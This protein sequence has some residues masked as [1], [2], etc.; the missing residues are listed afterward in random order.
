MTSTVSVSCADRFL[1][2]VERS[3][4]SPAVVDGDTTITYGALAAAA[5]DLAGRLA[6]A[7]V[8]PGTL[9]GVSVPRGWHMIA[10]ML[11]VWL[12]G[13]GYVPIDPNY[14]AARRDYISADATVSHL[15]TEGLRIEATGHD[16]RRDDVPQDTAYVIYTSGT[17]GNPKGVVVRHRNLLALLD[18][19]ADAMP[20]ACDDVSS[21]FHSANFDLS[22]W[23][24]W[25]PLLSGASC[26]VVPVEATH[27]ANALADLFADHG[28]T[29]VTLVPS[30]FANFVAELVERPVA[31]PRLRELVFCGEPIGRDT[32]GT[33]YDLDVAPHAQLV[34]MYGP[35]ETTVYVSWKNLDRALVADRSEPGTPIGMPLPHLRVRLLDDDRQPATAG[36][37]Y[38]AGG[39]VSAGYLGRPELTADRFVVLDDGDVWY[40]SGDHAVLGA[41][42]ELRFLGRKDDQVKIRGFRI[43]LGEVDAALRGLPEIA[44]AGTVVQTT[45]AGEPILVAG[46]VP[47]DRIDS[48]A[49]E[50]TVRA[51]LRE[52]LPQHMIPTRLVR[53]PTLPLSLSGKLN[54]RALAQRLETMR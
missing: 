26:V 21:V 36:E 48:P 45:S 51:R 14:P 46:Y 18:A 4:G 13:C 33:W 19:A 37:V 54:R 24:M 30:I 43:E 50:E 25:R 7:G 52:I 49:D 10:A 41:D 29:L 17:T 16:G 38:I 20:C 1:S 3:P 9:V 23:E 31:M 44:G 42:G 2:C 5:T 34:N 27:D 28:V 53:V 40:R 11:G 6:D 15:V 8:V 35:T 12:H 22:V 32:I 39:G 47:A